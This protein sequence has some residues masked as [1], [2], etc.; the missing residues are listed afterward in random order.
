MSLALQGLPRDLDRPDRPLVNE[1]VLALVTALQSPYYTAKILRGHE[2]VIKSAAFSPDG[3][4]LVTASMDGTA[5]LWDTATGKETLVLRGHEGIV[6]SAVYSSDGR[7][8]VTASDDKTARIW[9]VATGREIAVL[10]GH[11]DAVQL[12]AFSP[13]G[14]SVV[15]TSYN[16]SDMLG[17]VENA[18]RVW[19]AATGKEV[20]IMRGHDSV[21]SLGRV[22][23]RW[24]DRRHRV[25]RSD[26]ALVGNRDRPGDR[27]SSP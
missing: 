11:K 27:H 17:T 20:A 16:D 15:T 21:V 18:A 4:T 8:V 22:Q 10:R 12:A 6:T 24:Q 25:A 3:R 19:D 1:T 2:A 5:R 9:D 14:G 26:R 23:P 7:I 13:D